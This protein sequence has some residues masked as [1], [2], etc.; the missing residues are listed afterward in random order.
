MRTSVLEKMRASFRDVLLTFLIATVAGASSGVDP[1]INMQITLSLST[2]LLSCPSAQDVVKNITQ[3]NIAQ[4]PP[5]A[6]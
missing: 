3:T 4:S 2:Y 1:V 5:L 6:A